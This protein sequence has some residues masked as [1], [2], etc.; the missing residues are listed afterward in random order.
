MAIRS[1]AK[2]ALLSKEKL[3]EKRIMQRAS[4]ELGDGEYINLGFGMPTVMAGMMPLPDKT[5]ILHSECGLLNYGRM[6]TKE[7]AARY[8]YL[9][10]SGAPVDPLP[11]LCVFHMEEAFD[12]IRA[13]KI[14]W[15]I[16]GGLQVSEKG[17]LANWRSPGVMTSIGGAMDLAAGAKNVMV[18]MT[19]V[20]PKGDY[21]IVNECSF[22][23]TARRCVDIIITDIAVI[24]VVPEGL[25][26]R[27][28]APGW[29]SEQV[30]AQTEPILRISPELK[31]MEA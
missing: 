26:L 23:L 4:K 31:E 6:A 25:V 18:C 14:D 3:D 12:M 16:L 17:D 24:D 8:R 5:L 28:F 20:S 27:E 9:D 2:E 13:G 7:E 30:Q 1:T 10:G 22:P 21:K 15:T 11:G 19:H 29:D